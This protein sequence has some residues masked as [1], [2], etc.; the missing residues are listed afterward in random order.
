[1]DYMFCRQLVSGGDY[2]FTGLTA[3]EFTAFL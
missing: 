3:A 1:M 2:R